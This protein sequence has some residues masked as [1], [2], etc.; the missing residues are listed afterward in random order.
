MNA[1]EARLINMVRT[2]PKSGVTIW[3][4]GNAGVLVATPN[5]VIAIDPL[6]STWLET[7]SAE[8]PNPMQRSRPSRIGSEALTSLV[9]LVLVTHEHP[10]HLDP[11][12]APVLARAGTPIV[13]PD[14]CVDVAVGR[15]HER[16]CVHGLKS[17][18]SLSHGNVDVQAIAV[19][20][21]FASSDFGHYHEWIDPEGRHHAVGYLLRA[22]GRTIFH[23]GDLVMRRG[24]DGE[25]RD[26]GVDT[27]LLP[28]NGRGWLREQQGLVGNLDA[29]ES[30][31][32]AAAAGAAV[33]IPIHYDGLVGNT[34]SPGAVVDYADNIYPDL[35]VALPGVAGLHLPDLTKG[36]L[37][38]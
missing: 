12:L 34:S 20:H 36:L 5:A 35:A 19:P 23:G 24:L 8:N 9:D 18:M 31:D 13:V 26:H 38:G 22:G 32:L 17:G 29:R 6:T 1:S 30:V 7:K 28:V 33:L 11:G 25:L 2:R 21:A 15:G 37:H 27:C 10:D 3:L 4:T 14:G 16:D